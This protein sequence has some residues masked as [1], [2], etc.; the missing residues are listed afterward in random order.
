MMSSSRCKTPRR[1]TPIA[2]RSANTSGMRVTAMRDQCLDNERMA[3]NPSSSAAAF[4]APRVLPTTG[5]GLH[6]L[7]LRASE[8][9]QISVL[10]GDRLSADG[11]TVERRLV[12]ALHMGHHEAVRPLGD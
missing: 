7:H 4:S 8:L 12:A 9:Q 3:P 1:T 5:S 10:Q 6:E 11:R 2:C